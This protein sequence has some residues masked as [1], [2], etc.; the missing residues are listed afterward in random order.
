ALLIGGNSERAQLQTLRR[1]ANV[2]VAT[3]GRFE[4]LLDRRMFDLKSVNTLVLDE[5]DRMLDMGFIPAIRRIVAQL[6]RNRQTMCFSA[7]LEASVQHLVGDYLKKPV[8]VALGSI[9]KPHENVTLRA[10]EVSN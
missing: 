7:T 1:G 5:A 9:L 10:Y 2:I 4:D 3:P 6:P 8:R